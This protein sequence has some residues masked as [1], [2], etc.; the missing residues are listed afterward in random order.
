[1][2]CCVVLCRVGLRCGVLCCVVLYF[3]VW[4]CRVLWCVVVCRGVVCSGVLRCVALCCVV[5]CG[6]VLCC[7][8]LCGVVVFLSS[9]FGYP[10]RFQILAARMPQGV[11]RASARAHPGGSLA[12]WLTVWHAFAVHAVTQM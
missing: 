4:C 1:M 2:L 8:G 12:L 3:V 11:A 5:L 9:D 6:G 10:Q 7:V